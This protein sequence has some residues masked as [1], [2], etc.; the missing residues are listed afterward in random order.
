MARITKNKFKQMKI[1]DIYKMKLKEIRP[2]LK[3]A[4]AMYE[5]QSKVFSKYEGKIYSHAYKLMEEYYAGHSVASVSRVR[6]QEAKAELVRLQEFFR[7]EGSTVPGA[8]KIAIEA[9]RRIFGVDEKN[10]PLHRMTVDQSR[11]FWKAY[12]EF[13]NI[14]S[15]SYVRNMGSNRVQQMLAQMALPSL[16]S[17]KDFFDSKFFSDLRARVEE[18][19]QY[20]DWQDEQFVSEDSIFSG[21]RSDF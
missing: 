14:T 5:K 3:E 16:K 2:L 9:D 10:R 6:I 20:E 4:R 1:L 21:K 15:E 12:N 13:K 7:S 17:G 18:R 8:R 19:K 11:D